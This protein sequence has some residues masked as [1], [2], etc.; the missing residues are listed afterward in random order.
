MNRTALLATAL[1][2]LCLSS[3]GAEPYSPGVG[4]DI[5]TH[6]FWGDS[7]LHTAYSTDAG[8]FGGRLGLDD[9][10]RFA[11][12]EQV[13]SATG[14]PAKLRRPLDWLVIA[15]HSD[16][17]GLIFDLRTGTPNI[18]ALEEG[19]RWHAGIVAGGE[20][21]VEAT[22][23]LIRTFSQGRMPAEITRDYGPGATH[24]CFPLD[25]GASQVTRL[26]IFCGA[27]VW[28]TVPHHPYGS[29]PINRKPR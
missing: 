24:C 21:A 16:G 5:P 4:L 10:Y 14:Q 23:D 9:A 29:L 15:D 3:H 26:A 22:K 13:T 20:A 17:M 27:A 7:H 8:L 18:M 6:P 19:R 1:L 28:G 12:G 25:P 2:T 11:R